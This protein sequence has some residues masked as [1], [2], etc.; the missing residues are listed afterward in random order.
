MPIE[1][2]NFKVTNAIGS[3]DNFA[4]AEVQFFH[5][6]IVQSDSSVLDLRSELD[7]NET[8][9]NLI[10]TIMERGT[11]VYQRIDNAATGRIDVTMERSGWTAAT[12]Q[13]AIRAMGDTVGVNSKSVSLSVVSQTELKLDNS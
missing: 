11:I 9:H 8:M 10:R 6:T 4:G 2:K 7:F 1:P 3:T 13:A 12:L 5:I